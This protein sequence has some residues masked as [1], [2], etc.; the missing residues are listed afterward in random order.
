M[1]PLLIEGDRDGVIEGARETGLD[2][3]LTEKYAYQRSMLLR[4]QTTLGRWATYWAMK[5]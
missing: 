5:A 4:G 1:I 3:K 2:G